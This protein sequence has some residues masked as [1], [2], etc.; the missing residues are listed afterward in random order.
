MQENRL[1]IE[2][3][4][5]H[6]GGGFL[7]LHQLLTKLEE[8]NQ[9]TV[10]FLD[11]R[12]KKKFSSSSDMEINFIKPTI[13]SRLMHYFTLPKVPKV[14]DTLFCFGNIP[15]FRRNPGYRS[16]VYLQNWF[17]ICSWKKIKADNIRIYIR[18][19]IERAFLKIFHK[20]ANLYIVQTDSM[21]RQLLNQLNNIDVLVQPFLSISSISKQDSADFY[22]YP[23]RGDGSKNHRNLVKAWIKLSKQG[24]RPVLIITIDSSVYPDLCTWVEEMNAKHALN[25][26]NLGFVDYSKV[27]DI[28]SKSPV[29]I[30]PSYFE[31]FGMP[32]VEANTYGCDIIASELDYVRDV[33]RPNE[34][35][36]PRSSGSIARAVQRHLGLDSEIKCGSVAEIINTLLLR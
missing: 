26:Q 24:I 4:N 7:L 3:S 13:I 22:F 15:P 11:S 9:K 25:I 32:L 30:F 12:L 19:I 33:C 27:Y 34:T 2:A 18:L 14:N 28:Y 5:V 23:A 10:V 17:L 21:K 36:D 6:I 20:N 31:S 35:F 1:I 29:I 16:V 8:E